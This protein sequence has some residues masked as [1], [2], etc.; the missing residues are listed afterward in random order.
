MSK[1]EYAKTQKKKSEKNVVKKID[2]NNNTDELAGIEGDMRIIIKD[3]QFGN[4]NGFGFGGNHNNHNQ[5][6]GIK[7]VETDVLIYEPQVMKNDIQLDD[8]EVFN[9]LNEQEDKKENNEND[10]PSNNNNHNN[11]INDKVEVIP[12]PKVEEPQE[13]I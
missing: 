12:D 7:P 2:D 9:E 11:T 1:E 13:E 4:K 3:K 8:I 6:E 10:I 5:N